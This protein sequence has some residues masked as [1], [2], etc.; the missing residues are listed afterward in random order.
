MVISVFYF[1]VTPI[2]LPLVFFVEDSV[3]PSTIHTIL[4]D[5]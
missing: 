3:S 1:L 5:V 2:L 4:L